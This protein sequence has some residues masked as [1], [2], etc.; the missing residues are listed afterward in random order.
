[1]IPRRSPAAQAIAM[2]KTWDEEE[3][4]TAILQEARE[5]IKSQFTPAQLEDPSDEDVRVATEIITKLVE[6]AN[7]A[8]IKETG[9]P[10]FPDP[11][12]VAQTILDEIFG[13]GPITPL[14]QMETIEEI[15]INGPSQVFV[16]DAAE[17]KK[18]TNI[19][20]RSAREVMNLVNRIAAAQGRRLDRS[21]PKVD[22]RMPDGS[23]LHAIMEPL[24]ANVPI[25]VTIRRHRLV[26]RTINDLIDLGTITPK[27][28]EFLRMAVKAKINIIVAGGTASGKTNFLNALLSEC[29]D[30]E[31]IVVIEDTPELQVPK[32]DVVQLTTRNQT[33]EARA[34][35]IADLVI[36]ALRMR[37]DRIITGEARG[38]EIV[39]ILMAA[40][41]GH[42]GQ[43]LTIH[44]NSSREVIQRL[45][46][47]YLL[48][49]VGDVPLMAIRRQIADAF[50]LIVFLRQVNLGPKRKR[51]VTEVA[52]ILPSQFMEDGHV[53]CQNIFEDRGTGLNW[54]G[55]IPERLI[56]KMRERGFP[57]TIQFFKDGG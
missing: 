1:M 34:F 40:N 33:E 36:E 57:I 46:T 25:A 28:G 56:K 27:V 50:Q 32:R 35:T 24:T 37:P 41:T 22:C 3:S 53:V 45:E 8:A 44:A 42:E 19:T 51:L 43:M 6:A 54:T 12:S 7:Q 10:K 29:D 48:K 23:R 21:N 17:G 49:G 13:Y 11:Q 52:E 20:F 9:R 16:I 30:N 26:A 38:G 55:Y 15:I 47:M 14:L 31:R 4:L 2:Q 39:D 5:R 18:Q